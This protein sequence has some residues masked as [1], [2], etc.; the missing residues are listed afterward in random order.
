MDT[1]ATIREQ[2]L[3]K[4]QAKHFKVNTVDLFAVSFIA[5]EPCIFGTPNDDYIRREIEWYNA[6]SL[7]VHDFP[8]GAPAIWHKTADK[9][10]YVNS[11]YGFLLYAAKNWSQYQHVFDALKTEPNSRQASA[12]YTRPS[13][14]HEHQVNGRHDMICTNVVQYV[15]N[16]GRL[17]VHVQMRSND[18]VFGY[19]N[20]F[21]WQKHVQHKLADELQ[22]TPG[23]MVWTA[24]SLH[25]YDRHYYLL[26]QELS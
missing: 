11:N 4:Y 6:Q 14:H 17:D 7:N 5:D 10:G 23:V 1:V 19:K 21:A 20:D 13:I 24:S 18:A 9:N 16:D 25:V 2:F 3:M 15:I 22:V 12:I 8:G 26:D